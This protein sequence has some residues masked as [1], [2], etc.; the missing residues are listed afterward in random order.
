MRVPSSCKMFVNQNRH[1]SSTLSGGE[2]WKFEMSKYHNL[3]NL[4]QT[5]AQSTEKSAL[6]VI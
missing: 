4:K 3:G 5:C 6:C 1:R 2:R